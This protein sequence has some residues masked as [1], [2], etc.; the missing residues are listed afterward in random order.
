MCS[1]YR[2]VSVHQVVPPAAPD[3]LQLI[4]QRG[5]RDISGSEIMQKQLAPLEPEGIGGQQLEKLIGKVDLPAAR[6]VSHQSYKNIETLGGIIG[7]KISSLF[8]NT[9]QIC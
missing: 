3:T 1:R 4:A 8:R 5:Q 2:H 7:Q 9:C 6:D